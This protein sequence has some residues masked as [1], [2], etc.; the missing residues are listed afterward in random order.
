[1]IYVVTECEY[2]YPNGD[3]RVWGAYLTLEKARSAIAEEASDDLEIWEIE[4]DSRD[5]HWQEIDGRRYSVDGKEEI[6]TYKHT[7]W[8]D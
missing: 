1:M 4:D 8:S 3:R 7:V 6:Q 2:E 5:V